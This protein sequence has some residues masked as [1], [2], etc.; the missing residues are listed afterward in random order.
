VLVWRLDGS[1]GE[2]AWTHALQ[3]HEEMAGWEP[4]GE[5]LALGLTVADENAMRRAEV[6]ALDKVT[7]AQRQRLIIGSGVLVGLTRL[8]AALYAVV[9]DE[10]RVARPAGWLLRDIPDQPARFRVVRITGSP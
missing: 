4:L 10:A 9:G 8:G 5:A 3:R 1:T 2:V 7:G 6:A